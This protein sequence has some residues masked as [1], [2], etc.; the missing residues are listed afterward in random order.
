MKAVQ[1]YN[2][3]IGVYVLLLFSLL[4]CVSTIPLMIRH[5]IPLTQELIVEEETLEV[6]LIVV[7]FGIS[8]II[9]R[10][11]MHTLK[12]YQQ[13]A[14]Y[15]GKEKSRLVSRLAEAFKYIG[16]VNVEIKEIESVLGSVAWYPQSKRELKVRVDQLATKA[17][18]FAASPWMLVR[19]IDRHSSQTLYEH[20]VQHSD[21]RLPSATL[22]NRAIL[23]SCRVNGL[24]IIASPQRDPYL[25]TVFIL[26]K[27]GLAEDRI[28]LLKAI[29]N[30]IETI[31]IIYRMSCAIPDHP[32]D[33]IGSEASHDFNC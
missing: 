30:Q 19:M 6:T 28:I 32:T 8:F 18:T 14:E 24:Q 9:L 23:E 13:I 27:I 4:L 1:K 29:L 10:S 31:F 22:G 12:A 15:A 7:L 5:G 21:K 2:V 11:F 3:L 25:Q 26:P 20:S 16:T 17:M 33:M